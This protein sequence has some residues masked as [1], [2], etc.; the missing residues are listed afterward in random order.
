MEL[1]RW[2]EFI[3]KVFAIT[4]VLRISSLSYRKGCRMERIFGVC[5]FS[6]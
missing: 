6:D 5:A 1:K 4:M 2:I 3:W